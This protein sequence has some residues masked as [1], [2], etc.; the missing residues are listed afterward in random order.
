MEHEKRFGWTGFY[1]E[2]ADKLTS[3]RDSRL[4]LIKVVERVYAQMGMK[5]PKLDRS[6]PTDIDP[7]TVFGL[8]NKGIKDDNRTKIAAGLATA[9]EMSSEVPTEFP[10][11]P[12]LNNLSATFYRFEGERGPSDIDNL[13][14]AFSAALAYSGSEGNSERDRFTSAYDAVAAQ[15]GIKWNLTMG[16]F[17]IRPD[18]YIS[19][20]GRNRWA[21]TDQKML[22]DRCADAVA[23][24]K[25]L[26]DA[27][28]Y[29]EIRDLC[30]V[31]TS[32]PRSRFDGFPA[33]SYAAWTESERVNEENRNAKQTELV[34]G[35]ATMGDEGAREIHYWIYSPGAEAKKWDEFMRDG[36]AA[37]GWNKIGDLREFDDRE[38]IRKAIAER[39]GGEGSHKN[40]S[41]ALYQF[42]NEIMPGDIIFAKRGMNTIIGRGVVKSG[43][44]F[45]EARGDSYRHV[46]DVEWTDKGEWEYPEGRAPMKTLTDLT[47]YTDLVGKLKALFDES[48]GDE[49]QPEW[50]E[51]TRKD[52]LDDVYMDA[53]SYDRLVS[54][55]E[56]KRNV[57]LQGAPGVGKTFMAKRLAYSMMG[58]KDRDRV[59]L[60]QFHQSYSYEDFIIGY[61]PGEG[62]F[63]L[64]RGAFYDFCRR[65]EKDPG[66]DYFFIIDEINRGNLS[67]IFGELFML[68][69]SDK[70]G[71]EMRLLYS[72]E[73]FAVPKNLYLIGTMNTADRSLA[74][75]DYALRRRFAFYELEPGFET[76]GFRRY[77]ESL[78]S[79]ALDALVSCIEEL[80]AEI[81][82]DDT[83]GRGFRIGHSF[84]CNL[85]EVTPERLHDVVD[86]EIAPLLE[87]YWFDDLPR[88]REW[89]ARLEASIGR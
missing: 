75:M 64:K 26:P 77:R 20:D 84:L 2:L 70:R 15:T 86:Y 79:P 53:D 82:A 23:A 61:R 31:A 38:G 55:L 27:K 39:Y 37:L 87:E 1:N 49:P 29:L 25:D 4:E 33:F 43:Y 19:L 74:M 71:V 62:G 85:R 12:V 10:G 40:D 78:A 51:Y 21:L 28:A 24:L 3:Y 22:G 72:D 59:E 7:F 68:V 73:R 8:F 89:A 69:E 52:F 44:R 41:L 67:K 60:V 14:E 9:L 18:S 42:A 88:A 56:H 50:P 11:I 32:E 5:M 81:N 13:W 6:Q 57:I 83:L 54:L 63:E 65:A 35:N 76:E 16:L 45:D 46:R 34:D 66:N 36:I 47:R 17:W 48:E 30:K 58:A 80:N